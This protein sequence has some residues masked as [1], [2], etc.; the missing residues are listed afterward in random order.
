MTDTSTTT[1]EVPLENMAA[2]TMTRNQIRAFLLSHV[3]D[4]DF[5][6]LPLP[7]WFE[8]ENPRIVRANLDK[9]EEE[10]LLMDHMHRLAMERNEEKKQKL[11][12][13]RAAYRALS[14]A[15]RRQWRK[16]RH[17]QKKSCALGNDSRSNS[18]RKISG[19]I[20]PTVSVEKTC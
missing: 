15:E 18:D 20:Q 13:K 12:E 19:G 8:L 14:K 10:D 5:H 4:P 16:N 1:T 11:I 7:R 9:L 17:K 3:E 6:R 2:P